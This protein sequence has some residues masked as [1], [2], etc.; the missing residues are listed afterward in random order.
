MCSYIVFLSKDLF[1]INLCSKW[2]LTK[3]GGD[4][5]HVSGKH[6]NIT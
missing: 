6:R 3:D 5:S 2:D 1:E 4:I